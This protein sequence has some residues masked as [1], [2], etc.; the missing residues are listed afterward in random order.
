MKLQGIDMVIKREKEREREL[1]F[2][3]WGSYKNKENR[4]N[5]SF[6]IFSLKSTV[7]CPQPGAVVLAVKFR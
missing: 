3:K 1:S 7:K 2:I 6:K 4:L 5:I